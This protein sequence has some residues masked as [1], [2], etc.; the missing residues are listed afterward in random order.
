[1]NYDAIARD[2]D[3]FNSGF[4]YQDYLSRIL[5]HLTLPKEPLATTPQTVR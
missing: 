2:Y 1:M 4:D 3:R 5:P